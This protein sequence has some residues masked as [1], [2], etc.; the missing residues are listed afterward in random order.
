MP[1]RKSDTPSDDGLNFLATGRQPAERNPNGSAPTNQEK[2]AKPTTDDISSLHYELTEEEK[3]EEKRRWNSIQ[4]GLHPDTGKILRPGDE[5]TLRAEEQRAVRMQRHI[6]MSL[7]GRPYL[8][9]MD[10]FTLD[11]IRKQMN[12]L[13]Q[14]RRYLGPLLDRDFARRLTG[15]LGDDLMRRAT[16]LHELDALRVV[17]KQ[18]DSAAAFAW[19]E[20]GIAGELRRLPPRVYGRNRPG[21]LIHAASTEPRLRIGKAAK[22]ARLDGLD[23]RLAPRSFNL[24]VFLAEGAL[25]GAVPVEKRGLENQLFGKNFSEKALA[26]A[27]HKLKSELT[28]SGVC[29]EKAHPLIENVRAVGYR[30]NLLRS[31]IRIID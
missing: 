3:A 7:Y 18:M 1:G 29:H 16:V 8:T 2:A 13:E 9:A 11:A 25:Q 12:M 17:R 19:Y 14:Q 21:N 27:I 20:T 4:A 22:Q 31:D 24:L 28:K 26:Q 5:N 6:N 23:L 10:R 30:L 15:G